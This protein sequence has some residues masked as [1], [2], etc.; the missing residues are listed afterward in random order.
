MRLMRR[1]RLSASHRLHRD[2][3]TEE[4]NRAIYGKCNNPYGHGHDY[5]IEIGVE[6]PV[7]EQTGRVVA[8]DDLDA[9]VRC[10]VVA[11]FD[12]N[13]LNT[14]PEFADR[15][16]TTENLARAIESRLAAKWPDGWPRLARIRIEE[17]RRNRIELRH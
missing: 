13:D 6:G 1:Y 5:A 11:H 9:L 2:A 4:Q 17:T 16:A 12:H 15:P 10:E 7:D 3:F 14:L 8:L